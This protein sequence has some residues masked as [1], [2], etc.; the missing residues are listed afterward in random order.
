MRGFDHR[1]MNTSTSIWSRRRTTCRHPRRRERLRRHVV[2]ENRRRRRPARL[3]AGT[4]PRRSRLERRRPQRPQARPTSPRDLADADALLVRSATKV[5]ADLLAAAPRLRIV[6]RAGTGVDNIDVA[7]ASARGILVVNAPGANSIS[8]AEHACALM[9]ALARAVPAADRAMK[10]GKWEKKRFLGTELR[11]KTLGIAGL[12]RIGQE[13]A[14]R[15]RVVRHAHRRARSVH[16][17]GD[18]RRPRRRAAVARRGVRDRRLPDAAPAVDAGNAA[19]A[20]TTS[21]SRG[22]S[23]ASGIINTARG[24]LIDEAALRRAIES[25]IVAGA[26]ARRVREGAAGRLVARPAAA[27]RRDAAHRGVDRGSAGAGRPRHRGRGS[28][29][30]ARRRRAQRR[31]LPVGPSR[32]AAAAAAVDPA[33]RSA[34]RRSSSQMGAAR[35]EALGRALLRRAGR[36]PRR[37][38]PGG[39]RRGRRA[40]ADSVGRRVDRERARG[41]PRARHRDR[42][43]AQHAG[44]PLHEPGVDQAAHE[45]RRALGR[46]ARCSSRTA[47]G[48]CRCAA[49]TSRRRSPARC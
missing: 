37:R 15:A 3:G 43:V 10:D 23:R 48:W 24:E 9:L 44:A 35:I 16:L 46:R 33:G 4:A 26:G 8:V 49:S 34:W 28:R 6:G 42:R 31:E 38:D 22:A 1:R 7:A 41:G 18:R 20:S 14:Q 45:R 29:F 21:G 27:G 11:G 47:R 36:E 39:E 13:V 12:G 5:D 2:I 25:G 40:A 17:A 30:P 19:S 32:R